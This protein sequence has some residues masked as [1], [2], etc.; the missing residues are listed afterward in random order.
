M[1]E[2]QNAS[3]TTVEEVK[4]LIAGGTPVTFIDSRNPIAW[5]A[6]KAKIAGAVRIPLDDVE[7]HVPVL[8]RDQRL[9]VYCT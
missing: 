2:Q 9:V 7:R 1:T 4:A 6:S 8:P 3:A 5:G